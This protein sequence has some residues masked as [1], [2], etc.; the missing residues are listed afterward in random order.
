M[1]L[2]LV[3]S[4]GLPVLVGGRPA[5][6][7]AATVLA[8]TADFGALTLAGAGGFKPVDSN[9]DEVG[10]TGVTDQTGATRTWSVS[11]G[12]LVADGTP[13]VDDGVAITCS[14]AGETVVLTVSTEVDTYDFARQADWDAVMAFPASTLSSKTVKARPDANITYGGSELS[15]KSFTAPLVITSRDASKKGVFDRIW[16]RS[17]PNV[18]LDGLRVTNQ[19]AT[20]LVALINDQSGCHDIIVQNCELA[21]IYK[22][23]NGDYSASGS[24]GSNSMGV[25]TNGAGNSN[26]SILSNVVEDVEKGFN[27]SAVGFVRIQGN[28]IHRFYADTCQISWPGESVAVEFSWNTAS[29]PIGRSDDADNPHVDFIQFIGHN[30][31]TEHWTGITVEGNRFWQGDARGTAQFIFLAD[32][33]GSFYYDN[34]RIAG[35]ATDITSTHG[36]SVGG[37][38]DCSQIFGNTVPNCPIKIGTNGLTSGTHVV[39]RNIASSYL[40]GGTPELSDNVTI[41][42]TSVT[43]ADVFDGSGGSFVAD[44]LSDLMIKLSMKAH[45]PAD[46]DASG[47][48]STGDAGAIGSG[49]VAWPSTVPGHDGVIDT[50]YDTA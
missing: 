48:A 42:G 10:L 21:G 43:L 1:G 38:K 4:A 18:T 30:D 23:P 11:G 9:G 8:Q 13:D 45:G 5:V 31:A 6:S 46:I 41:D 20:T 19:S 47:G 40:I 34:P 7:G 37:A 3:S 35:N 28:D 49:Y 12:R 24:Y 32:M 26:I 50:A 2:P 29:Q 36:I 15:R 39:H 25:V 17:C 27:I 16:I 22:D 14:H 33:E 44:D